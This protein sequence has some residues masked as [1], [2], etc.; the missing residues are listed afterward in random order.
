VVFQ[1]KVFRAVYFL[2]IM[3]GMGSNELAVLG[4]SSGF[5]LCLRGQCHDFKIEQLKL[6]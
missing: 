6:Q 4:T 3:Q 1:Q 2:K 5:S